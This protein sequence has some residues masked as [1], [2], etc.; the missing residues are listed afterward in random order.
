MDA[1]KHLTTNSDF[2]S[3]LPGLPLWTIDDETMGE[4]PKAQANFAATWKKAAA[5]Q[6][7]RCHKK[8][9]IPVM[10]EWMGRILATSNLDAVS[11]RILGPMDNNSLDKTSLFRCASHA[12]AD[13]PNRHELVQIIERELPYLLRW[14]LNWTPPEQV[15]RDV[16]FVYAAHHEESLLDKA[17]QSGKAAP[18]KELLVESLQQH[19]EIDPQATEW[20]GT[21]TQIL[22]LIQSNPLNDAVMRSLRLEQT[23]RYLESLQRDGILR[24]DTELGPLKTRVWVFPRFDFSK[25]VPPSTT[26]ISSP[27]VSNAVCIFTK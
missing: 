10:T 7:I 5:N 6:N 13:F 25:D 18:F 4:S 3:E 9:G 15:L 11:S 1:A 20:R 27:P 21:L 23:Q 2:N 26:T 22:R 16:R 14:L 12:K 24:C 8:Y 19:F 17:H